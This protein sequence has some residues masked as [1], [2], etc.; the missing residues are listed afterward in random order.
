MSDTN[1]PWATKTWNPVTGCSKISAGCQNCYAER[2]AKTRLRGRF[3]Y[4][5]DEPFRVTLHPERLKEP[6]GWEKPQK[7][8]VCSMGDLFHSLVMVKWVDQIIEVIRKC[9]QHTFMILTK[10][11]K[12]FMS[13]LEVFNLPKNIWLGVT[14]ENNGEAGRRIEQLLEIPSSVR[15]VSIEPMLSSIDLS[16][17][18]QSKHYNVNAI[19]GCKKCLTLSEVADKQL[20][21]LDWVICGGENG[22]NARPMN[23][24][25]VRSLRDQCQDAGV[26]FFF[27]SWG[28][29]MPFTFSRDKWC[30]WKDKKDPARFQINGKTY[31]EWPE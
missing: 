4:P 22:H 16:S 6:L 29:Y 31:R 25:W 18:E 30:R 15:Y 14:I 21:K 13:Y 24:E 5:A 20:N 19:I 11:P 27:K 17:I 3:G 2:M 12:N 9:P 8:F 10:R 1:I 7:I 28:E 26:P 23:P